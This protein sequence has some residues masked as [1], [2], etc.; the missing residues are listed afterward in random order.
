M[1]ASDAAA[2]HRA[3]GPALSVNAPPRRPIVALL[4]GLCRLL[5][6]AAPTAVAGTPEP[7]DRW[8]PHPG[9]TWQWQLDGEIDPSLDVAVYDVDLFDVPAET[10]AALQADGRRV[11]CYVSVGTVED[12][13]PDAADFPA[14]VV[15]DAYDEWPGERW[16]DV[17]RIDLLAPLLRAR[18][19]LC[20]EKGFDGVEPD[21]VDAFANETGFDLTAADQ[22]EFLRW[23]AQEAHARGLSIGLK[24]DPELVADL[25]DT[26]DWALTEDCYADDWCEEMRPFVDAGKA[27]FMAEYTDRLSTSRFAKRVCPAADAL[28]FSAILKNR[29]LDAERTGCPR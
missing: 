26:F 4:V 1:N 17:R 20:R 24:N 12:W 5:A 29:D 7:P 10:V 22:G 14:A 18:L 6:V 8:Q 13:R 3:A 19:D 15:G 11:V 9:D 2:R 28:G 23:L 21:N 16:L 25:V 27:V